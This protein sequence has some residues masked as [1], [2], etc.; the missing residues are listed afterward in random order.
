MGKKRSDFLFALFGI[1]P[2]FPDRTFSIGSI[3]SSPTEKNLFSFFPRELAYLFAF[4]IVKGNGEVRF[5]INE[6]IRRKKSEFLFYFS[7]QK[8]RVPIE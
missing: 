5:L 6:R 8:G 2:D 4:A 3:G 1:F 7:S